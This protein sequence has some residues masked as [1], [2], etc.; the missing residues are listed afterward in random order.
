MIIELTKDWLLVVWNI[1]PG[2]V[3]RKQVML[4]LDAFK[5]Q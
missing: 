5:T 4:V 3:L 2:V 1:G